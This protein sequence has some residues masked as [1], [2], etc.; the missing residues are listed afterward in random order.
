MKTRFLTAVLALLLAPAALVGQA[1]LGDLVEIDGVRDNTL[2]GLGLVVGLNGTGDT[3]VAARAMASNMLRRLRLNIPPELI[4]PANVAVVTVTATLGPFRKP[5]DHLDVTASSI[6]D[7]TSLFGGT[8]LS[9][10]LM[11][12]DYRTVYAL[13]TGALLTGAATAKGSSGSKETINHPT[14]GRIPNGAIL[15]KE[16][17]QRIVTEEGNIRMRLRNPSYATAKAAEAAINRLHPGSARAVDGVTIAIALPADLQ[18]DPVGF[19]SRLNDVRIAVDNRAKVVISE[20]NG[21]IVAGDTVV[22]LP[23]AISH[24]NLAISV[25][26]TPE[27]SHPEAFSER[28]RTVVV[29]RSD[30]KISERGVEMREIPATVSAGELARALNSLGVSPRDLITIFQMLKANGALQAE[31]EVQ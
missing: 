6:G 31:L 26:E 17:A 20:R 19:L 3:G 7:S 1:R 11:G 30:V 23:V 14:V 4:K 15:E 16:V 2:L 27:V 18:C 21:T 8:L 29:P 13:A 10:Q 22:V 9:T 5:G 25:T 12:P 24:G 28:G